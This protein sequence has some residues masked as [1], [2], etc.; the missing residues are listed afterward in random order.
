MTATTYTLYFVLDNLI[1]IIR[2]TIMLCDCVRRRVDVVCA[3]LQSGV[4]TRSLSTR[5]RHVYQVQTGSLINRSTSATRP[6]IRTDVTA[7][8]IFIVF[9]ICCVVVV[10]VLLINNQ[11]DITPPIGT[12]LYRM[13]CRRSIL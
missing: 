10:E 2:P 12:T 4:T 1:R 9:L 8:R 13:L 7:T 11:P 5:S 6:V 3:Q